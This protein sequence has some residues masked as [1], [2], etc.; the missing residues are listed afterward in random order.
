M[1]QNMFYF[2]CCSFEL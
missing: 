2:E 1:S